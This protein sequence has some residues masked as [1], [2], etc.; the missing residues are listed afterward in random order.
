M[1]G[2]E[3]QYLASFTIG[4]KE[5]FISSGDLSEFRLVEEAGN[6]LP[7]YRLVFQ[8][9]DDDLFKFLNEGNAIKLKIGKNQNDLKDIE[10]FIAHSDSVKMNDIRRAFDITGFINST[11]YIS[12]DKYIMQKGTSVAVIRSALSG[13][14]RVE[15]NGISAKDEQVW[16]C[17]KQSLK[18]FVNSVWTHS[19]VPN[20]FIALG[21]TADKR[22][23]MKDIKKLRTE[24]YRWRFT[25][26]TEDQKRDIAP[27][28]DIENVSKSGF[29]N[30]WQGYGRNRVS[31][32]MNEETSFNDEVEIQKIL[33][34][35]ATPNR[36]SK[37]LAR[38]SIN[39]NLTTNTHKNYQKS[40]GNNL[41]NLAVLSNNRIRISFSGEYK[42]IN[43][44]DLVMM[45]DRGNSSQTQQ[46]LFYTSGVYVVSKVVRA[47]TGNVYMTIVEMC[48]ESFN[49]TQGALR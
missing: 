32:S 46:S 47:V 16:I 40:Y 14:F 18:R 37:L 3:G 38:Q 34:L 36:A 13:L 42:D 9:S 41:G 44:L 29:L 23:I 20:S 33:S 11:E 39:R 8:T 31:Y 19:Y 49:D 24:D 7:T 28:S 6:V 30:S 5:D 21:I 35:S 15:D 27:D 12:S 26:V 22:L 45:K 4:D 1:I 48:R 10:L 43:I 25:E 17:P 2:V